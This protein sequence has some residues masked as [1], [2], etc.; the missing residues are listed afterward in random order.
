[1]SEVRPWPD[2]G[3]EGRWAIELM[4][5]LLA[6]TD[7]TPEQLNDRAADL[8]AYAARTDIEEYREATLAV[9]DRYEATA[10]AR[11]TAGS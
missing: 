6:T 1:M 10:A 11:V 7:Q 9:A 4:E 8:R 2:V 5:E 3:E